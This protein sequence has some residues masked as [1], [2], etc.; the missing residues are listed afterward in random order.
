MNYLKEKWNSKKILA[1]G[2]T[3]LFRNKLKY[4]TETKK[5]KYFIGKKL[6]KNVN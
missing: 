3:I 6:F 2:T 5:I 1:N 4:T